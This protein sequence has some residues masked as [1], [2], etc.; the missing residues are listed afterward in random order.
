V[1]RNTRRR[2]SEIPR[3]SKG[4]GKVAKAIDKVRLAVLT[5]PPARGFST[6]AMHRALARGTQHLIVRVQDRY[7]SKMFL[8]G[9]SVILVL[10]NPH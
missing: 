6:R 3:G 7:T 2:W 5:A 10:K 9:D 4:K 8:R 1:Q